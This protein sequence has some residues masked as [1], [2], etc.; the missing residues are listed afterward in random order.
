MMSVLFQ[1]V[2]SIV[3]YEVLLSF[4]FSHLKT[5]LQKMAPLGV[6]VAS[7]RTLGNWHFQGTKGQSTVPPLWILSY[8]TSFLAAFPSW[9]FLQL[10][11][12]LVLL[13]TLTPLPLILG[14]GVP[15][16]ACDNNHSPY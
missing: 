13:L 12:I 8:D 9:D 1:V 14:P 4:A 11:F 16:L 15:S 3:E 7:R 10:T 5:F 2:H 6:L